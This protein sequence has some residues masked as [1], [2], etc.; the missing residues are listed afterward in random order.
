MVP[1]V[2]SVSFLGFTLTNIPESQPCRDGLFIV[3]SRSSSAP[4]FTHSLYGLKQSVMFKKKKKSLFNMNRLSAVGVVTTWHVGI[5]SFAQRCKE[6]KCFRLLQL[7][8]FL[9]CCS[10][11]DC[12]KKENVYENNKLVRHLFRAHV[13]PFSRMFDEAR[14]AFAAGFRC[15]ILHCLR[16]DWSLRGCSFGQSLLVFCFSCASTSLLKPV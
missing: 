5:L 11:F 10:N 9:L 7:T 1:V 15:F 12:L 14:A 6:G 16:V 2:H 3:W 13:W 4:G 8:F